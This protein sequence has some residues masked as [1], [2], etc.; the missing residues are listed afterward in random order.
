MSH[1]SPEFSEAR[2]ANRLWPRRRAR[3]SVFPDKVW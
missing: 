2:R 3:Q 1:A